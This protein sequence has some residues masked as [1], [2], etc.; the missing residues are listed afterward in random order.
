MNNAEPCTSLTNAGKA[1]QKKR[2]NFHKSHIPFK[3][4]SMIPTNQEVPD[5]C[6][7]C[8]L[9]KYIRDN[10]DMNRHYNAVHIPNLICIDNTVALQ[11][12][13][14]DVRSHGW[15][16]TEVPETATTTAR[17]DTG[18]GT[19]SLNWSTT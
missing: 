9:K 3:K 14:S 12:K 11:C 13:C 15:E 19:I 5:N 7:L 18:R 6:I 4:S 8:P 16:K 2:T 10:W 1:P 17:S